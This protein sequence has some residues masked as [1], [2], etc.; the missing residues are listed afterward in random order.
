MMKKLTKILL[1]Y[2]FS[3]PLIH[4]YKSSATVEFKP[5]YFFFTNS[6]LS[7]IYK[8]GGLE[9]QASGTLPLLRWLACHASVGVMQA[10][11][12]SLNNDQKTSLL[13]LPVDL[14]LKPLFALH[15]KIDYYF[16]FGPRYFYLHQHN[17]SSFVE[18]SVHK[19]VM[20]FFVNT[21]FNVRPVK[22]FLLGLFGEYGYG[23]T[24]FKACKP[25]VFGQQN[26]NIGGL[27]FGVSLGY[28][29]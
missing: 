23:K 9:A 17:D 16:A 18:E 20:G 11:G 2:L 24:S 4:A 7:K 13:Q 14:G 6:P 10:W 3:L 28:S 12:K 5:G 22:H 8:H 15:K 19:N 26:V 27:T 21:G 25:N 1:L 29:F